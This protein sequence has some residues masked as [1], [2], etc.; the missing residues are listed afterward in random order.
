MNPCTA[1]TRNPLPHLHADFLAILP[2]IERHARFA[3]RY[4]HRYHDREDAVAETIALAWDWYVRL[5]RKG[6]NAA[7]FPSALASYA[8]RHIHSDRHLSGTENAKDILSPTA[9]Q[10]RGFRGE[11]LPDN[12]T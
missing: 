5:A 3:F 2:T 6:K 8:S 7:T 4:L 10:R 11:Q 9:R 1:V 12:C